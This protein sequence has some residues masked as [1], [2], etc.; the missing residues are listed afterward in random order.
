[1]IIGAKKRETKTWTRRN[2]SRT[3]IN[4]GILLLTSSEGGSS[5]TRLLRDWL[6]NNLRLGCF[7]SVFSRVE[8]FYPVSS[9]I[10]KYLL[11]SISASSAEKKAQSSNHLSLFLRARKVILDVWVKKCCF[12]AVLG[13]STK[14]MKFFFQLSLL[15]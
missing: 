4:F 6:Y 9:K 1:M 15:C 5:L 11:Q 2:S 14:G 13:F 7:L 3:D 12:F 8:S 10:N